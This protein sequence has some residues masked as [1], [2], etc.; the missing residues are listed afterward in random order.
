MDSDGAAVELIMEAGFL[1]IGQVNS[2]TEMLN[3]LKAKKEGAPEV[4]LPSY[5]F[6]FGLKR[7]A[8]FCSYWGHNIESTLEVQRQTNRKQ[9][10]L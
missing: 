7:P 6:S 4:V 10:W 1:L 2:K 9:Y 3:E 5:L 8:E